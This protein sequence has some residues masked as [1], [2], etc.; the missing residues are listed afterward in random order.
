[1]KLIRNAIAAG[2]SQYKRDLATARTPANPFRKRTITPLGLVGELAAI[3][4]QRSTFSKVWVKR[5]LDPRFRETL[6]LAVARFND[7]STAAGRT[8]SGP[9]SKAFP[10][11][12]RA[13]R[14]DGS[15]P[16]R[17][18][19]LGCAHLRVRTGLCALRPG[20]EEDDAADA[21]ALHGRR[22]SRRSR[23]WPR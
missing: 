16:F 20:V 14:A 6:M 18:Q 15:R 4:A 2:I 11:G 10:K 5:E 3:A 21:G 23:S 7:P 12:A 13:H 1:M 19:D 8:T 9:A 22:K 17:P